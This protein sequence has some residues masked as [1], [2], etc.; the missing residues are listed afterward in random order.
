MKDLG[1]GKDYKYTPL[2]DDSQQ[3]YLPAKLKNRRFLKT[4]K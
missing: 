4:E 2:E 3:T 1:Y